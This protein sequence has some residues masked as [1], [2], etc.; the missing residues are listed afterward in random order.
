MLTSSS[1]PMTDKIYVELVR[2]LYTNI[3]PG[4]IMLAVFALTLALVYR[5]HQDG[6]LFALGCAALAMKTARLQV[7]RVYRNEALTA[8]LDKPRARKLEIVFAMPYV[9]FAILLGLFGA[10]AIW[11]TSPQIHMLIICVL[12]GYCAGVATGA[13]MRPSIAIPSMIAAIGPS[14]AVSLLQGDPI[15]IGMSIIIAGYLGG[16]IQSVLLW[17][18]AA[19]AQITKRLASVSLARHDTL[20]A[21]PNRLALRE[22]FEDR[23][24]TISPH[25]LIAVHYLDLDHFKPVN[26]SYGHAVGDA[27]LAAVASRLRR[28][29]RG[30]DVVARLGGDEFAVIQFGLHRAEEAELLSR[31]IRAAIA[32]PF[33]IGDST[34]SIS[35][36]I[37]TVVSHD[38]NEDLDLLL[39]KADE[40]LY[41]R[42]RERSGPPPMLN[43]A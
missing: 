32:Q 29:V 17:H 20:T 3:T 35:T 8:V 4:R 24:S 6:V 19:R 40:K 42:K 12:V 37:G 22:Y 38:R 10:R 39:Q 34:I 18:E 1:E 25:G 14:L 36:C 15:Y 13:S 33:D 41:I 26:D 7:T 27:L 2:S 28:A 9:G 23:A 43:I 21:L 31:R 16:G 5:E 11:L 30:G